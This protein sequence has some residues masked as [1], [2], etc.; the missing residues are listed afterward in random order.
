VQKIAD[1]RARDNHGVVEKQT[2]G[3]CTLNGFLIFGST[4]CLHK[5]GDI[6]LDAWQEWRIMEV[7]I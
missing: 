2:P 3:T 6:F 5:P 7:S 4:R 1:L